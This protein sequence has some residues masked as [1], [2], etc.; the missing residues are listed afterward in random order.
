MADSKI[1]ALTAA[2]AAAAANEFP[3]NEAGTTKKVT[4]TQ[5]VTATKA[6]G[7]EVVTGTEDA[8]FA[9]PSALRTA[10]IL[11]HQIAIPTVIVAGVGEQT[12]ATTYNDMAY[13]KATFDKSLYTNYTSIVFQV[14]LQQNTSGTFQVWCQLIT[15]GGT[16]ITGSE[17]TATLGQY[18][19][20]V[21]TS[22]DISAYLTAGAEGY[23]VQAKVASG[24]TVDIQ[25]AAI[26][27]K[28]KV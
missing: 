17:V 1:S 13:W 25:G 15:T 24:G 2:S 8:K 22:G 18:G 5:I 28:T 19:T 9:T 10:K 27:V 7:A 12:T 23:R 11:D 20:S 14:L 4:L 6:T 26:I 16:P 21:Q 3:I